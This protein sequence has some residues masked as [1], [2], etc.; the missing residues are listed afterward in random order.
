MLVVSKRSLV[1]S[2]AIRYDLYLRFLLANM[3]ASQES[4]PSDKACIPVVTT[5]FS[6]T[7][8]AGLKHQIQASRSFLAA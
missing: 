5:R 2:E 1:G 7:R 6:Y 4:L 8:V 3:Y